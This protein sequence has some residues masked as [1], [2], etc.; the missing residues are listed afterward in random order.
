VL[1]AGLKCTVIWTGE[2]HGGRRR[3]VVVV[4]ATKLSSCYPQ[5]QRLA[6][7][8]LR[9]LGCVSDLLLRR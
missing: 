8:T 9:A 2:V 5:N 7:L 1:S 4:E 6:A 3:A